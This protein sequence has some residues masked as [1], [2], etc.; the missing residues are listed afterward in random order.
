[1]T[2]IPDQHA[3]RLIRTQLKELLEGGFAPVVILL[4]E[5]NYNKAG[6]LLDGLPFSA[7]SLLEHMRHRQRVLLNFIKHPENNPDV[8]PAAYWPENPAPLNEEAWLNAIDSFERDLKEMIRVVE[9][10]N[11]DLFKVQENGKTLFWAALATLHHN[12]YTIGQ[13]KA[14]GRQLGIW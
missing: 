13:I 14:I 4:R 9:S 10:S 11:I 5:F 2:I 1:M 12:G 3:N 7:W 8:W 6:I